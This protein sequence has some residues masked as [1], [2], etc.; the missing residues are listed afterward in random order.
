MKMCP[1]CG[2]QLEA[3]TSTKLHKEIID[4]LI[5]TS[6]RRFRYS[7][8]ARRAINARMKDGYELQDFFDVHLLIAK[9]VKEGSFQQRYF[10][11]ATLYAP[12]KFEGYV[13]AVADKQTDLVTEMVRKA[14]EAMK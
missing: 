10:R 14:R 12:S 5:A 11:P 2:H 6:G 7:E 13:A 9:W 1:N 3:R 8:S 4:H